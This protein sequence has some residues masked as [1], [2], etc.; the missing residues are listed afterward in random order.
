MVDNRK[1]KAKKNIA[2][3]LCSQIV[4]L[5]CGIIVPRMMIGVF[6]SE[7][8][9][10]S[11]SITQFLAY[12]TL[13][14]GGVGGVAR[15]VLYKPLAENDTETISAIMAEIK[16]FF[17]LIA[18]IFAAYVL[19][20]ALGFHSL[21]NV[22]CMDWISTFILVIVISISTFGQYFVGISNAIL[23]QADQKNYITNAVS[24]G[25]TLVNAI[26]I[27]FLI[28]C[29]CSFIT[30]KLVSS[31]IFFL[32]PVVLWLF[33]KKN[34]IIKPYKT[35]KGETFLEQKWSGLGQHIAFFL[36]SN[37]DVVVL[38]VL[39]D[40]RTVAVYSVYN[41]IISHVQNL[42]LSFTSGME[43]LFGEMLARGEH[44]QLHK[45]FGL[46][47]TIMS[48]VSVILFSATVIL[49]IPF[50]K[51]YTSGIADANYNEPVFALLLILSALCY[52]IRMPYHAL[53]I[54]AG[55]FKQTS[56]AAY[57]EVIINVI[58]SVVLVSK[59]GLVGVAIGTLAATC[60]R[61]VYYV[62]YLS[63]NIIFR[64]I[65][66]FAKRLLVNTLAGIFNILTGYFVISKITISDYIMWIAC[67]VLSAAIVGITTIGINLVF[68]TD[69]CKR[70]FLV[71]CENDNK[72]KR[73]NL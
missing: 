45:T 23:L 6:G 67:G 61:F 50:I 35:I 24:I 48:I 12:I 9:G 69:D 73:E 53:V 63:K 71:N 3:S 51:L 40:L 10:A 21:A 17:R 59:F 29:G 42:A 15:A 8:Y 31:C 39:A 52:C 33:V 28:G 26:S 14:E 60:F 66:M 70:F 20:L 30:V 5:L 7:A 64:K 49:I 68:Y 16:R 58:L 47:E 65:N 37:T 38:T 2:T 11:S 19:V 62:F 25:A 1:N 57:G 4:I 55:H 34:Y 46:Y 41:M 13:L 44:K 54:A 36:H 43:A 32:R 56:M 72:I 27:V 18:V 22:E